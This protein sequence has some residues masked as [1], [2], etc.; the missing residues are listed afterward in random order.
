MAYIIAIDACTTG[1][2]GVNGFIINLPAA[3]NT[4]ENE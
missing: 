4:K 1:T 2:K 3:H